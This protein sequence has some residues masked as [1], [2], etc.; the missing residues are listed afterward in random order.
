M[1]V[2]RWERMDDEGNGQDPGVNSDLVAAPGPGEEAAHLGGFFGLET[3]TGRSP[4]KREVVS[5]VSLANQVAVQNQEGKQKSK[6]RYLPRELRIRMRN[7]VLKY[8]SLGL[9]INQVI[10][11]LKMKYGLA[12]AKSTVIYWRKGLR[13]PFHGIR[14]PSLNFLKPS[15]DLA[16]VIGVIVGDGF[17][18]QRVK[19]RYGYKHSYIKQYNIGLTVRDVEFAE[20]FSK[21]IARVLGRAPPRVRLNKNCKWTVEV[22]SKTL[23]ELLTKPINIEKIKPYV[24][25]CDK[26]IYMFLRG[27]FDSDG[28]VLKDGTIILYNTDYEVLKYTIYLLEKIG[29]ETTSKEPKLFQRAG[30]LIVDRS[31]GKI[32]KGNKDNYYVRVRKE[33]NRTFLKKVGFTVERKRR[34]LEVYLGKD[35]FR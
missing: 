4:L 26:C 27:F 1:V 6:K 21:R 7:D 23:F 19:P 17:V 3:P 2:P 34:R 14:I 22:Q 29:I 12:P 28:T 10:K 20:E 33:S 32:Y 35:I 24:E 9:S 25:H 31:T 15:E 16:Y 5:E 13:S 11:R 18:S 30:K 8:N